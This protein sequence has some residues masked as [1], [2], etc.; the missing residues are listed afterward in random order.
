MIKQSASKKCVVCKKK[1]KG[2]Q[3]LYCSKTCNNKF[4][5]IKAGESWRIKVPC[6]V[7][8]KLFERWREEAKYCSRKCR[9]KGFQKKKTKVQV[10]CDECGNVY[11]I[12]KQNSYGKRKNKHRVCKDCHIIV[13]TRRNALRVGEK[14]PGWK[15]GRA[16]SKGSGWTK[17]RKIARE[18]DSHT[19]FI[20][21]KIW[22][23]G[24]QLNVHHIVR[25]RVSQD[26][27]LYNLITLCASC[28]KQVENAYPQDVIDRYWKF[29]KLIHLYYT[30][31]IIKRLNRFGIKM[32]RTT[33]KLT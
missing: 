25:H 30:P 24:K 22:T 17:I 12:I 32:K 14:N 11:F 13:S 21:K 26:N 31:K 6:E 5:R 4:E 15:G 27:S 28:H 8:R 20:C 7:C 10:K 9:T 1:L 18:R 19:C 16:N 23:S 29:K 33:G 3:K 2:K